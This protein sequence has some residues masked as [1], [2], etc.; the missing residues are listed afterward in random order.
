M[1]EKYLGY[2]NLVSLGSYV[3]RRIS[4]LQGTQ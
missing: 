4:I 1:I 3:Q 2:L